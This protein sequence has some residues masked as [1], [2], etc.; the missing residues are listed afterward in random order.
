MDDL[1]IS[2]AQLK[3]ALTSKSEK[4]WVCGDKIAFENIYSRNGISAN[5]N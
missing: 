2:E 3:E 4:M 5:M 1:P